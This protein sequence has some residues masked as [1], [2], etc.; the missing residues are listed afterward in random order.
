MKQ[1]CLI[2]AFIGL[3][4]ASHSFA[5]ANFGMAGCGLG[6]VFF[7]PKNAQVSAA[8]TNQSTFNQVFGITSGTS[9][10][11]ENSKTTAENAQE[12][13]I[14]DNFATLSKE[15]AQG[16]GETLK[17]FSETFGC[18]PNTF[19]AFA[20]TLQA[21]YDDIFAAPGSLAALEVIQDTLQSDSSAVK[22]CEFLVL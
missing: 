11:I 1:V 8:T 7:G 15:I 12:N 3:L 17:A 19:P 20:K 16:D 5:A 21:S 14:R 22:G 13:F 10:C 18:N 6:S 2:I 9:N 4:S